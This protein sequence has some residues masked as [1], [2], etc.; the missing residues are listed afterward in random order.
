LGVWFLAPYKKEGKNIPLKHTVP[1]LKKE[2]VVNIFEG[3]GVQKRD[4]YKKTSRGGVNKKVIKR[5][6]SRGAK[7][8]Y[9]R[10]NSGR[11][12]RSENPFLGSKK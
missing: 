8:D 1:L 12:N 6:A 2:R 3:G 7:A 10:R 9:R 11:L 4:L 5:A